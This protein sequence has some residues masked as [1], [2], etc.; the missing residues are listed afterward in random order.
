MENV[1]IKN[2]QYDMI[3]REYN[4]KQL[5]NR[6]DQMARI[7]EAYKCI[8]ALKEID[9]QIA[10]LSVSRARKLLEGD[11]TALAGLREEIAACG[12][13]RTKLLLSNGYPADY[14]EQKYCCEDCHDTGYIGNE[15]CHCFKQAIICL[16]YTSRCV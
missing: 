8:P 9:A 14:L 15:K 13:M 6:R 12:Q 4:K 11:D 1:G 16:L 2:S 10:A 7:D 3:I 5:Q